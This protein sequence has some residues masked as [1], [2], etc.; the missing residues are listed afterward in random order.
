M[1]KNENGHFR[2]LHIVVINSIDG[3]VEMAKVFDTYKSSEGFNKL[4]THDIPDGYI[5]VAACSDECTSNLSYDFKSWFENIGSKEIWN[6]G[7][8]HSYSFIGIMGGAR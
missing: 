5:I 3:N 8:R 7:Y 2:G 4:I 1:N 6:I